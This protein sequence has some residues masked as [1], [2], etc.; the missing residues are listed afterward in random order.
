MV[1]GDGAHP[2]TAPVNTAQLPPPHALPPAAANTDQ[3]PPGP[4]AAK[5][6]LRF[7]GDINL[8][9]ILQA[10]ML[11]VSIIVWLVMNAAKSDGIRADLD[12]LQ[13]RVESG[14]ASTRA[15]V[16]EAMTATRSEAKEASARL[17]AALGA[18]GVQVAGIPE[19][20]ARVN[21]LDKELARAQERGNQ[22]EA[23][24]DALRQAF[25]ELRADIEA[26]KRSSAVSLPGA[27]GARR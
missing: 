16:K 20:V 8:G 22:R 4:V 3:R 2:G 17:E 21:A 10:A 15:E 12:T 14:Q 26:I 9:H 11:G 19:M 25:V 6:A 27:P 24:M 7:S 23:R 18:L 13:T 1:A 5:S